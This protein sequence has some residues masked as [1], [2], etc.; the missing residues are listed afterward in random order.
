MEYLDLYLKFLQLFQM[1]ILAQQAQQSSQQWKQ[2][3]PEILQ[4]QLQLTQI[5]T[6]LLTEM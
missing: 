3:F 1:Y 2:I 6:V 5:F 4:E